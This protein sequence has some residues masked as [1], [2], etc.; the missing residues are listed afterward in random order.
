MR[1]A[2]HVFQLYTTVGVAGVRWRFLS[3]NG[4]G[5]ARSP[6]GYPSVDDASA[7]LA[8]AIAALPDVSVVVRPTSDNRW[9]CRLALDGEPLVL[10]AGAQDRRVRCEAAWQRFVD[11]APDGF[12]DPVVHTF[13]RVDA[14]Y[15]RLALS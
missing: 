15:P 4:R 11:S 3:P 5:L 12:V 7:G 9:R 13:R 14:G 6:L 2:V 10:G 8:Q 1:P